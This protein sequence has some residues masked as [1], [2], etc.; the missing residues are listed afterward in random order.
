MANKKDFRVVKSFFAAWV[1]ADGSVSFITGNRGET[2]T[3]KTKAAAQKT[4]RRHWA[5]P[6]VFMVKGRYLKPRGK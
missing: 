5:R 1:E 4:L 6:E 3:W 2:A